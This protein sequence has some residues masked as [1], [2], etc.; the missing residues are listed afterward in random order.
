ME[1]DGGLEYDAVRIG[2]GIIDS[3]TGNL[4]EFHT[5]GHIPEFVDSKVWIGVL[6]NTTIEWIV[7]CVPVLPKPP[8]FASIDVKSLNGGAIWH[9]EILTGFDTAEVLNPQRVGEGGGTDSISGHLMLTTGRDGDEGR[10]E[11]GGIHL[12]KVG[13]V[14]RSLDSAAIVGNIYTGNIVPADPGGHTD[15]GGVGGDI[16]Y[17]ETT[18][19]PSHGG[20][21][22]GDEVRGTTGDGIQYGVEN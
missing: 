19:E 18:T 7:A 22:L 17:E 6:I 13:V 8:R 21:V 2:G 3:F 9:E 15:T 20:V 12:L 11:A 10:G 1:N 16:T 5:G 4:D 14:C